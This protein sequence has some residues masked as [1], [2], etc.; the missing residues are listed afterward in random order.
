MKAMSFLNRDEKDDAKSGRCSVSVRAPSR[1]SAAASHA[2]RQRVRGR[3][4]ARS[5]RR[6]NVVVRT[7][8]PQR[9][10]LIVTTSACA[11]RCGLQR[12]RARQR[13]GLSGH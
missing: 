8:R 6:C 2:Q 9:G 1:G 11:R 5:L 4:A 12:Q 7:I 3:V 10:G 13:G